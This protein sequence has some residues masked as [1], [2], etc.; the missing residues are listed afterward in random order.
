LTDIQLEAISL[1]V[2]KRTK[3]ELIMNYF[4]GF[5]LGVASSLLASYIYGIRKRKKD[6]KKRKNKTVISL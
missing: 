4:W 2:N 1:A 5:V 3:T 6:A